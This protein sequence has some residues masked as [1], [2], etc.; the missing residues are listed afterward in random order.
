MLNAKGT[1][2]WGRTRRRQPPISI[3][4]FIS[5]ERRFLARVRRSAFGVWRSHSHCQSPS[6]CHSATPPSSKRSLASMEALLCMHLHVFRCTL[7]M[8]MAPRRQFHY[9]DVE[10]VDTLGPRKHW[11][12]QKSP[13]AH[14]D[15]DKSEILKVDHKTS[16]LQW[17]IL[18]YLVCLLLGQVVCID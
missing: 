14:T 5:T 15:L 16:P 4:I 12:V 2:R 18:T 17:I 10:I 11:V 8:E 7:C 3:F 1:Q 6:Q 13:R 9:A